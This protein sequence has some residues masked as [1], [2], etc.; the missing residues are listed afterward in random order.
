M[1]VLEEL[2]GHDPERRGGSAR[3]GG[4]RARAAAGASGSGVVIA[5]GRVLTNAHNLRRDEVDRHVRRR[6][7]AR[8]AASLAPTPTSTSP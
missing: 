4:G 6:A 8:P 7:R 1:T 3:P 5:P 2:E